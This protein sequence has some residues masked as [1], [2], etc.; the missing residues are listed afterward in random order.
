MRVLI[1]GADGFI[2]KNLRQRLAER[3]DAEVVCFT[4]ANAVH[5][6]RGKLQ[7]VDFVCHLAGVNRPENTDEFRVGNSQLTVELSAAL[8]EFVT[9]TGRAVPVLFASSTQA[10]LDN[11]YGISKREAEDALYS[12]SKAGVPVFVFRL[13]NVFGKWCRPNYNSVVA[14]FCHNTALGRP[15]HVNDPAARLTLAYIDD[16]VDIFVSLMELSPK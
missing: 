16:V 12:A 14:T 11:A 13:P 3:R 5:E 8:T 15:I 9:S 4:R 2:A 6:L 7:N 10:K 1:T